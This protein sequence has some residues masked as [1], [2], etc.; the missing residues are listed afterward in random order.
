MNYDKVRN[1]NIALSNSGWNGDVFVNISQKLPWKLNLSLGGGGKIGHDIPNVYGYNGTWY[2]SY[3]SLQRSFLKDDRLSVNIGASNPI[4]SKYSSYRS[5]NT[6]GDFTSISCWENKQKSFSVGISLRL[7]KL[8]TSVK[9]TEK[10][11][12][13]EDVVGGIK[14]K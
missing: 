6:Q 14:Q 5:G 3:I 12:E 10:T 11:I 4:G 8:S 9:K 2:Y 7:G 13:N 1:P